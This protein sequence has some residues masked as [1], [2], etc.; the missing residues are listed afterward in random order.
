MISI[1]YTDNGLLA[2]NKNF[3]AKSEVRNTDSCTN[4]ACIAVT[5]SEK[6]HNNNNNNKNSK[7]PWMVLSLYLYFP[8][9]TYCTLHTPITKP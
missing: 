2:A 1:G 9:H 4:V 8:F 5:L 6:E 7:Q 3:L